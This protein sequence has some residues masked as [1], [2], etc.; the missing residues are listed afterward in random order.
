MGQTGRTGTGKSDREA[1]PRARFADG[2][3]VGECHQGQQADAACINRPDIRLQPCLL[4]HHAN[5]SVVIRE[6]PI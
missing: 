2:N 1:E 6:A 5:T 4:L 3:L